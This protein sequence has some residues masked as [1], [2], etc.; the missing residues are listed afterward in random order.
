MLAADLMLGFL[1]GILAKLR[2]DEDYVAWQQ[3]HTSAEFIAQLEQKIADLLAKI[4]IVKKRCMA[5]ILQ[6]LTS[7]TNGDRPITTGTGIGI[8]RISGGYTFA[9]AENR[10]LR[11]S[12]H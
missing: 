1:V 5:G 10:A 11:G 6:A 3:L 12:S 2:T 8:H 9:S 4:E 7:G